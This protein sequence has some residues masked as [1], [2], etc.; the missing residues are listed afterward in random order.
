MNIERI[1]SYEDRR[2]SQ[3][4]LNQHGCF[5]VDDVPYEIEIISDSEAMIHGG[6]SST[7]SCNGDSVAVDCTKDIPEILELIEE[8]RFYTPHI[9]RFYTTNGK[10]IKEY[11]P[12]PIQTIELNRIQPSQFYV[13]Q[14]KIRAIS[15]FI[16]KPEDI[17][18]QVLPQGDHFISLDG[19][20]RLYYAVTQGWD[21][22]RAVT[23]TSDD[24]VY[25]FVEEAHRRGVRTPA[26]MILLPHD[27]YE[28]KWNRFCDEFF[29]KN[30]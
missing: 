7:I 16:H 30:N 29:E 5:L 11:S 19:H 9:F 10:L 6:R 18:I 12:R 14:D 24:W 27:Q 13:D 4:V 15:T 21:H 3:N 2:F 28:E 25:R 1:N 22:V 20:T 26:D 23:D 17:L 8:F